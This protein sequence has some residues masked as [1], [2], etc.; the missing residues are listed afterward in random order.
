MVDSY[1]QGFHSFFFAWP[2]VGHHQN[3]VILLARAM[4]IVLSGPYEGTFPFAK[5]EDRYELALV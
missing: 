5:S 2:D 1:V 3:D 4:C